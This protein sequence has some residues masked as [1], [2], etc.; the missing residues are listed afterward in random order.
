LLQ[1]YP[2]AIGG[3]TGFTPL[4]HTTF[5][6]AASRDDRR[7]VVATSSTGATPAPEP[8][9]SAASAASRYL[10][11]ERRGDLVAEPVTASRP[12][13]GVIRSLLVDLKGILST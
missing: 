11:R 3:K 7:L 12:N 9:C 13:S 4:A 1:R 6:G 5:V 10:G 8:S 2:G